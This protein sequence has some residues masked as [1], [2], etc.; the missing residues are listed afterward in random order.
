MNIG[1]RFLKT[2]GAVL[3]FGENSLQIGPTSIQ[4]LPPKK[5]AS[6]ASIQEI[7]GDHR[8]QNVN[9]AKGAIRVY[10]K[11]TTIIPPHSLSIIQLKLHS[12]ED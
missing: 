1:I 2:I 10:N 11:R 12:K 9:L 3:D 4:L 5:N 8:H 7:A 6:F